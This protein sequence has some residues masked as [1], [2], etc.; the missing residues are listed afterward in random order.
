MPHILHVTPEVLPFSKTGGLADV[1]RAL[2]EALSRLGH[3]VTVVTPLYA[4]VDRT[5]VR[6]VP[7]MVQVRP[8]GVAFDV[9]ESVLPAGTRVLFLANDDLFGRPHLYATR[10]GDY[11]DN[12]LRFGA[13]SSAVFGLMRALRL[14]PDVIHC[15]D[16]QAAL[17]PVYNAIHL[18][19]FATVLTIH[20]LAYQGTF[21]PDVLPV[22][23][24]PWDLFNLE[25]MEFYGKVNFLKGGLCFADRITTVSPRYAREVMTPL[26]GCGLEGLLARRAGVVHGI[27]NGVDYGEWS[28][29]YDPFIPAHFSADAMAGKAACRAALVEKMGLSDGPGPI[30]GAVG[31]LAAQKGFDLLASVVPDM[32]ALG[33]RV[34]ILGTGE[35]L[36]EDMLARCAIPGK[37]TVRIAYDNALAHLIEAGSDFFVMPSRYEP[38]GLNQLYSMAY[39]TLPIVHAVGGLDD[40]V[41]DVDEDPDQATGLKFRTFTAEALLDR[42]RRAI[43]LYGDP[44][45]LQKVISRAM[46]QDYSWDVAARKYL[47]LYEELLE[48]RRVGQ[49]Q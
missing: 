7:A 29:A 14:Y 28:P 49:A 40:T 38:C 17:V 23:G 5:K 18:D 24:L 11:P 30:F 39:G 9:Y 6:Q 13:F 48:S 44:E 12:Y 31:R 8:A 4:C 10:D 32:V 26:F 47:T 25:Q 2:P 20:N 36:V 22:L 33:A 16:W 35:A 45:R 27:L 43:S 3:K 37:V 1:S 19:L 34:V 42:V 15:H 41:V 21:P 46:A